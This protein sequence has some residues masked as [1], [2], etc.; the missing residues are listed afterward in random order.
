M[1]EDPRYYLFDTLPQENRTRFLVTTE[2]E[3]GNAPFADIRFVPRSGE[4]VFFNTF[5]L[6]RYSK[7]FS[8][9][10]RPVHFIFHHAF[11]G[12]TLLARCLNQS[13]AFFALKEPWIL[14]RLA[15]QKRQCRSAADKRRWQQHGKLY[16]RLL[17]K[18][19]KTGETLVIKPTNVAN[20][21]VGDVCRWLPNARILY[22]YSGL[23]GFLIS[24]L[25]KTDETKEKIPALTQAFIDDSDLRS[26]CRA[27]TDF[28]QL[29]FLQTCAVAWLACLHGLAS[30]ERVIRGD[31]VRM[32][33]VDSF[34]SSPELALTL[35]SR[36]FGRPPTT[37]QL[38]Q[39][40]SLSVLG[41]HA[42]AEDGSPYNVA[43][44]TRE[45]VQ[46]FHAYRNA[47]EKTLYWA[48]PL[49]DEL[50]LRKFLRDREL[51]RG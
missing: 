9:Q 1:F 14:R 25:K 50:G 40:S 10:N 51:S 37:R 15:D 44:R 49:I 46:I 24:N 5:E 48:E 45:Y 35:V 18:K 2:N 34:L 33:D 31:R 3:L 11:V 32:L 16:M 39:M 20:N 29:D 23:E 19:Y 41:V 12:S 43:Q 27:I 47:I 30:Q 17:C 26:R 8:A 21:L 28:R 38:N 22:L 42:K 6:Q 36:F 4:E 7:R 13:D